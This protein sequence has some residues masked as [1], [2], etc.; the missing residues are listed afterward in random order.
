MIKEMGK[1]IKIDKLSFIEPIDIDN[2]TVLRAGGRNGK[3]N[4]YRNFY[5]PK[6][7]GIY[8]YY[9]KDMEV[10]YIGKATDLSAR[11]NNHNSQ[12]ESKVNMAKKVNNDNI[13]FYS[14]AI[15]ESVKHAELMEMIYMNLFNP[16]L[17]KFS[18]MEIK[19]RMKV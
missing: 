5:I 14:Y 12:Y 8:I 9:N 11:Y 18:L 7:P 15:C 3:Y 1:Y 10:M 19:D 16:K 17:N 6:L 13:K 2:K 4:K